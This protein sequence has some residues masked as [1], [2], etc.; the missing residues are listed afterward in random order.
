MTVPPLPDDIELPSLPTIGNKVLEQLVFTH[1]SVAGQARTRVNFNE[2]DGELLDNEKLEWVGDGIL[3]E[4]IACA[5]LSFDR[6]KLTRAEAVCTRLLHR[7]WP[8]M[9]EGPTTVSYP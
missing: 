4:L 1:S 5:I 9:R 2:G 8:N 6:A 3:S 7:L